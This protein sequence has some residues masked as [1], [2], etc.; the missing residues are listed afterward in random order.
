MMQ[1]RSLA[2]VCLTG[3]AALFLIGGGVSDALAQQKKRD[4][5]C[6]P[7][8]LTVCQ[9]ACAERG[10]QVRLCPAYCAQQQ[11]EARCS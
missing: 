10:G 3:L 8:Y 11:R 2:A 1:K 5:R 4:R 7:N 9:K 6:A